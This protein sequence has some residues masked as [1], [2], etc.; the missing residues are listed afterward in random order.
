MRLA[1][2]ND[3]LKTSETVSSRGQLGQM[4]GDRQRQIAGLD[5]AGAGDHQQ[6]L[7][8]THAVSADRGGILWHY[9]AGA[10]AWLAPFRP[11]ASSREY[12]ATSVIRSGNTSIS[13]GRNPPGSPSS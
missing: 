3:A 4:F 10:L 13:S 1:L 2:S 5:D 9:H 12:G 11:S 8:A 7:A 6:R